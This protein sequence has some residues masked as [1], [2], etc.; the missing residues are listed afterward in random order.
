MTELVEKVEK[1][2]HEESG[3]CR[4][5]ENTKNALKRMRYRLETVNQK[6]REIVAE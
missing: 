6:V 1:G 2:L 3:V 4:L 5:D